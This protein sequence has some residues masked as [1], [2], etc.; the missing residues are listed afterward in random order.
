LLSLDLRD[1]SVQR[2][3][4][5][6]R[7]S[8]IR[9]DDHFTNRLGRTK[10]P[11]E[12]PVTDDFLYV[13]GLWL[14]EGGKSVISD[15]VSLAFSIGGTPGAVGTLTK[16]FATYGVALCKSPANG[17]DY[18]VSSSV[19]DAV[20]HYLGLFG[21]AKNAE[22]RFPTFF[23]DLSQRQRRIVVAGL[24]DGDGSH[25][26]NGEAVFPQKSHNLVRDLYHCL[27]LDGIF[28]VVKE[29]KNEQLVLVLGRAKDFAA[30]ADLYP[31]RHTTKLASIT[32]AGEIRGKDKVTGLWK[33]AGVWAAVSEATL[34][35][36][37][38]TVVYN[39]GGKYDE[40]VRAQRSA[41]MTVPALRDL[42]TSK[43]AFWR[44]IGM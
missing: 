38:K 43:L 26:N 30:F 11:V 23:W 32:A 27:T 12:F 37:Q 44:V 17:F 34:P 35:V 6:S 18:A 7:S 29:G 31:L 40:S 14:A 2:E 5:T 28:P 41:F 36:G 16:F 22:K 25:V 9:V 19:F 4:R 24:W 3:G 20:F 33:C 15:G 13:V 21:T 42:A 39:T 1:M 10:V 8:V